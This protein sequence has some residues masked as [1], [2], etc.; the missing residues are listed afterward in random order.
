MA[1]T[2]FLV[3][4]LCIGMGFGGYTDDDFLFAFFWIAHALPAVLGYTTC[5]F[6]IP[7]ARFSES[8]N[9]CAALAPVAGSALQAVYIVEA[10]LY[11]CYVCNMVSVTYLLLLPQ[12]HL[13]LEIQAHGV[14]WP[15]C[16]RR[17]CRLRGARPERCLRL[18]PGAASIQGQEA[19][20]PLLMRWPPIR[21]ARRRTAPRHLLRAAGVDIER[22]APT[23]LCRTSMHSLLYTR[24]YYYIPPSSPHPFGRRGRGVYAPAGKAAAA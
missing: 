20:W 19:I 17:S 7:I 2:C 18:T 23:S 1:L 16:A 10:G 5:T 21:C 14:P 9:A 22:H 12:A 3:A 8:G 11:W 15:A 6:L 4:F 13:Q 24:L